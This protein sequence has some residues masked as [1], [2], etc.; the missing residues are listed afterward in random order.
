MSNTDEHYDGPTATARGRRLDVAN[1]AMG[2]R[3]PGRR[4]T[5]L[6]VSTGLTWSLFQLWVASPL[7]EMFSVF[8]FNQAEIRSLHL[9][10][11]VLL[12]F[13]AYPARHAS[14]SDHLPPTDIALALAAALSAGF[15]WLCYE[16]IGSHIGDPTEFEVAVAATGMILLLEATRRVLGLPMVILALALLTYIFLGEQMPDLIAHKGASLGKAMGH[17]WLGTEGVFGVALGVSAGL[18]FLFVLFGALLDKLLKAIAAA[19][20]IELL[21]PLGALVRVGRNQIH[22]AT[23]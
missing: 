9:A 12:A 3:R 4:A 11:A 1:I 5:A 13:L 14:A 21:H 6:V 18:I 10:F 16:S 7:P 15:L 2:L 19:R 8:V 17:L 20:T 22:C 23:R